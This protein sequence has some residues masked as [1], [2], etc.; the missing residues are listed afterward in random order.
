[1]PWMESVT[2]QLKDKITSVK[3]FGITVETLEKETKKRENWTASGI[4]G[5]QNIWWKKLKLA[6]RELKT[7]LEQ[8]KDNDD[9]IPVWWPSGRTVLLTKMEDLTDEKE[10]CP[11]TCLNTSYKVLTGLAGKFM[12]N[13][14]MENNI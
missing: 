13:H 14:T 5:I 2:R 9:L 11:I 12:R 6:V 4:D 1:M 10:Y 3:E 7:A 8:V